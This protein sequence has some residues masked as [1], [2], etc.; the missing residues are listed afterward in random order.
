MKIAKSAMLANI[1][2]FVLTRYQDTSEIIPNIADKPT[3]QYARNSKSISIISHLMRNNTESRNTFLYVVPEKIVFV[4]VCSMFG[5]KTIN[6][7][8]E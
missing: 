3:I 8:I 2:L 7:Y 5:L 4:S 1:R 6:I